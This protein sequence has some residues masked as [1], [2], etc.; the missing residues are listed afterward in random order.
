MFTWWV[1]KSG[2]RRPAVRAP[3]DRRW[4]HLGQ[5]ARQQ[6]TAPPDPRAWSSGVARVAIIDSHDMNV[7]T[8]SGRQH[9]GELGSGDGDISGIPSTV[10]WSL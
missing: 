3:V 4:C 6:Q 1:C 2:A 8:S 9:Q 10:C 5:P 7:P